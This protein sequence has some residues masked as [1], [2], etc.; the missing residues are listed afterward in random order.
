MNFE[1]F[2]R[3][4]KDS[5][6][7]NNFM[8]VLHLLATLVKLD[9]FHAP[10]RFVRTVPKGSCHLKQILNAFGLIFRANDNVGPAKTMET[11]DSE[12]IEAN[13]EMFVKKW[14]HCLSD[15]SK[16]AIDII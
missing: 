14:E 16:N 4:H 6:D 12:S 10:Q 7:L 2:I 1:A 8:T 13:L 15:E 11:P 5:I 3:N 9:L